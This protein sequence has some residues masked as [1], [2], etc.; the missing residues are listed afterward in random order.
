MNLRTRNG[1]GEW[2]DDELDDEVL[3]QVA[4]LHHTSVQAIV[5]AIKTYDD[6]A[7]EMPETRPGPEMAHRLEV[8]EDY[9]MF[10]FS[11]YVGWEFWH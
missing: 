1:Y 5:I 10:L 4:A 9:T 2:V 8:N 7:W 6:I 3:A 11:D